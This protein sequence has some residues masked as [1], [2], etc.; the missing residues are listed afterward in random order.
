MCK[1][2][3]YIYIFFSFFLKKDE[4]VACDPSSTVPK[5]TLLK[6]AALLDSIRSRR[7]E[8][9]EALAKVSKE[10]MLVPGAS[11]KWSIKDIIAHV[12]WWEGQTAGMLQTKALSNVKLWQMPQDV[13]NDAVYMENRDRP[14]DEIRQESVAASLWLIASIESLQEDDLTDPSRYRQMPAE[15]TPWRVVVANS[16]AHYY[17]HLPDIRAWAAG[18]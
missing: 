11:G 15:W 3:T 6:K 14:L 5:E 17:Q 7:Q 18:S 8:W 13:R 9:D 10:R 2:V 16:Y 1:G 12:T 4:Q